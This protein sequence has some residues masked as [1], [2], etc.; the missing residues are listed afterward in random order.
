MEILLKIPALTL[1]R[2]GEQGGRQQREEILRQMPPPI[3]LRHEP[4]VVSSPA[5]SPFVFCLLIS[6]S[7]AIH[8]MNKEA[9]SSLAS[10]KTQL[11]WEVSILGKTK[12]TFISS[13]YVKHILCQD[14]MR[15]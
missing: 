6:I 2:E 15:Y 14:I 8:R 10:L 1:R 7:R 3:Q 13:L 11:G 5:S 9:T 4:L 12:I